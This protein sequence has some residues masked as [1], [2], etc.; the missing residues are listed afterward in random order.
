MQNYSMITAAH[1]LSETWPGTGS[2]LAQISEQAQEAIIEIARSSVLTILNSM[3]S[4]K[5]NDPSPYVKELCDYLRVFQNHTAM[6]LLPSNTQPVAAFLDYV[7]ETFLLH[8]SLLRPLNS[9][10]LK[11]LTSDLKYIAQIGLA[12]FKLKMPSLELIPEFINA[13]TLSP[14]DL[15]SSE[16]LPFWF[17]V[18]LLISQSDDTLL[19][20]HT[21][22]GWT[23]PEYIKWFQTHNMSERLSFLSSLL[24]TYTSSVISRG[25]AEY[26]SN[27]PFIMDVLQRSSKT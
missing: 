7:L 17:T 10:K 22:T 16:E 9:E 20:P 6:F 1:T 14:Q 13:F 23:I 15:A 3:H 21:S 19:S 18:Q 2:P 12:P 24:Q 11:C 5:L 27:Y 26:D 8:A 4:E 25:C